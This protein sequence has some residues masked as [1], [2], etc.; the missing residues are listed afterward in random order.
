MKPSK[1]VKHQSI[2]RLVSEVERRYQEIQVVDYWDADVFAIGFKG[3]S[4]QSPLIYLSTF[5]T[6]QNFFFIQIEECFHE[7]STEAEV[8]FEGEITRDQ[9]FDSFIQTLL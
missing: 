4:A 8:T 6:D 1:L 5:N 9:F 7:S 3:S 2:L